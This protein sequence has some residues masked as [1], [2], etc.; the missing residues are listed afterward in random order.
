MFWT[1]SGVGNYAEK[2]LGIGGS[3][4]RRVFDGRTELPG[5]RINEEFAETQ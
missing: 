3:S 1:F 4:L 2:V 5:T